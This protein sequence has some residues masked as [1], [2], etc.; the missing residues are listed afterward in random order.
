M[1]VFFAVRNHHVTYFE[2]LRRGIGMPA[3]VVRHN[4]AHW[5]SFECLPD[6]TRGN[7]RDIVRVKL[8]AVAQALGSRVMRGIIDSWVEGAALVAGD[9]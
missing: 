8:R 4:R 1:L 6:S 3:I 5:P 7:I 2:Q 9:T